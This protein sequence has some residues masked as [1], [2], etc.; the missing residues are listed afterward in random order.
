MF[1]LFLSSSLHFDYSCSSIS[2]PINTFIR[3]K[4]PYKH[5]YNSTQIQMY[6]TIDS[7]IQTLF[8]FRF[9][10]VSF[11]FYRCIYSYV[12]SNAVCVCVCVFNLYESG[13]SLFC[14]FSSYHISLYLIG[15]AVALLTS[16]SLSG[17]VCIRCGSNL[18][19]TLNKN[20]HAELYHLL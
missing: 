2:M 14:R 16:L 18:L 7:Q 13:R 5:T 12:L 4:V 10:F 3:Q 19:V 6:T 17:S 8:S 1:V 15:F 11:H 9:H 20:E